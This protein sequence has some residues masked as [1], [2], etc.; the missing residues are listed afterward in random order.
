MPGSILS[1]PV[2][3]GSTNFYSERGL[4]CDKAD[5]PFNTGEPIASRL[6]WHSNTGCMDNPAGC[7]RSTT[8]PKASRD[9]HAGTNS[10]ITCPSHTHSNS[11]THQHAGTNRCTDFNGDSHPATANLNART[12]ANARTSSNCYFKSYPLSCS[13]D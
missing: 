13:N 10:Y 9:T 6:H 3:L 2:K 1:G 8:T 4:R 11:Y 5:N 7:N 12:Y